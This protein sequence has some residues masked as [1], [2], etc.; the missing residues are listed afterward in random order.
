LIGKKISYPHDEF[1]IFNTGR[2]AKA[3]GAAGGTG[4]QFRFF[5]Y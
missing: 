4:P 1:D 5:E 3:T 2:T